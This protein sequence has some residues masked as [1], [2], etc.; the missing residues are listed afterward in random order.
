MHLA[1]VNVSLP[2]A[3]LDS[4]QLADFMAALDPVNALADAAPGFVWRMQ[5]ADG[6]ATAVRVFDDDELIVNMSVWT[7][8][9]ALSDFVFDGAHRE[10]LRRRRTWFVRMSEAM[11]AM[12]WIPEG[13]VPTVAEGEERLRHLRVH[14]P[15]PHAFTFRNPFPDTDGLA[16]RVDDDRSCPA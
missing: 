15:T 3:P 1:Q 16:V 5:T 8:I 9:E 2:V 12:W 14:G 7:S 13:A 4:A 6:N 10:V 11:E